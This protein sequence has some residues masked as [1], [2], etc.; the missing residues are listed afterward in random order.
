M[1]A[2]F[3]LIAAAVVSLLGSVGSAAP[4]ERRAPARVI[5]Q[6]T[7]A[8]TFALTFDDGPHIYSYDLATTLAENNIKATFFI[9]GDNYNKLTDPAPSGG[10]YADV[11]K[12]AYDLGHQI[13]SHTYNH[14]NL[15]TLSASGVRSQMN[16]NSDAIN[17]AIGR[18][19][20][21]MRPPEGAYNANTLSILGDLGY[22]V[23]MWDIDSNDW[24]GEGLTEERKEYESVLGSSSPSNSGHISLQ[25]DVYESTVDTLVPWVIN[26]VRQRGYRFTTVADCIGANPYH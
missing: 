16:Q 14:I 11:L 8:G 3:A 13:A 9:N 10:T 15:D 23:V 2:S 18:R 5:R 12:H 17:R 20:A 21:F 22:T 1:K 4:L 6:C 24:R 19:P 26:Y 25:H 7:K